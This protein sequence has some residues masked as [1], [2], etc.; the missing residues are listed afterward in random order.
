MGENVLDAVGHHG[1]PGLLPDNGLAGLVE[2]DLPCLDLVAVHLGHTAVE[3]DHS[4]GIGE[5]GNPCV[6]VGA[7]GETLLRGAVEA[8]FALPVGLA[9]QGAE[10]G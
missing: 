6:L 8:L 3:A 10:F 2:D 1:D 9:N 7:S 4:L 5:V